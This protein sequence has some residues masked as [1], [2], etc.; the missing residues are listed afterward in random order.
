LTF[1]GFTLV[2]VTLPNQPVRLR[3]AATGA[4]VAALMFELLKRGFGLY[5]AKFPTYQAIYGALSVLPILLLWS[6]MTWC[7]VLFGAVTAASL[8]RW[9]QRGRGADTAG[10]APARKLAVALGLLSALRAASRDGLSIKREK[11]LAAVGVMPDEDE[12]VLETLADHRFI[13]RV[14]RDRW[15]LSRDLETVSL[16]QLAA[17]FGLNPARGDAKAGGEAAWHGALA[18]IFGALEGAGRDALGLN[19]ESFLKQGEPRDAPPLTIRRF[20]A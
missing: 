13:A 19:V 4:A 6:Y 20:H 17:L 1:I 10:A 16:N 12:S 9:R 11:L 3:H 15:L 14:G 18:D 8:P 2:Y 5:L 7:V